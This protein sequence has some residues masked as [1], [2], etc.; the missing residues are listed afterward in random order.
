[1]NNPFTVIVKGSNLSDLYAYEMNLTYDKSKL[2]FVGYTAGN[3]GFTVDPVFTGDGVQLA[4]TETGSKAGLTGDAALAVLTFKPLQKGETKI[5]LSSLKLV[6]SHLDSTV[7]N[8]N[9]TVNVV[10]T[11]SASNGSSKQQK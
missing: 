2:Q 4:H 11:N 3:D 10:V 8:S 5:A 6:N 9:S 7:Y 1:V